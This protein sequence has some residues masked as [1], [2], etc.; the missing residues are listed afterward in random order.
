MKLL[1]KEF[2]FI[3]KIA[4]LISFATSWIYLFYKV[5]DY[6][7]RLWAYKIYAHPVYE[8]V[9]L[10]EHNK[11]I[12]V[13]MVGDS[14]AEAWHKPDHLEH[15][16]WIQRG[17]SGFTSGETLTR[18]TG[19]LAKNRAPNIVVIQCGI[20]DIQ[21]CGY[22][23]VAV[24]NVKASALCNIQRMVELCQ[25]RS[26]HVILT[27]IIPKGPHS[28]REWALWSAEM[29]EAV[30]ELNESILQMK[31]EKVD[32]I[33]IDSLVS[34]NGRALKEFSKDGLHLNEAG[35]QRISLPL[36]ELLQTKKN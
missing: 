14:R 8:G 19:D 13:W 12:E 23:K 34:K 2:Q 24:S 11:P 20:N 3:L 5:L 16:A 35:Y 9:K 1:P 36:V 28:M 32:I 26:I 17:V 27:T 25:S 31:S 10:P 29:T 33:E 21:A 18:L 15:I 7:G 22:G 6:K 30:D 4:V